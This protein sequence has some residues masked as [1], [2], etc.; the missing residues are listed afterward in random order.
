MS[1]H[2]GRIWRGIRT[3]R[4]HFGKK[5]KQYGYYAPYLFASEVLSQCERGSVEWLA[6]RWE[7][8]T[9]EFAELVKFA[10]QYNERFSSMEH[11]VPERGRAHFDQEWFS[12][13]DAVLAY[14]MVRKCEPSRIVEIGSGYSTCFMHQA[15][16]DGGIDCRHRCIDP[17]PGRRGIPKKVE[18]SAEPLNLTDFKIFRQLEPGDF[19]FVDGSHL[20][21]P[22]TDVDRLI[23]DI[24]PMLPVGV[25]VHFHDILLPDPYPDMW[26][27]RSYNEQD[28]LLAL[29][30]GGN[31]YKVI[32][33]AA[34]LRSRH[35]EMLKNLVAPA[36]RRRLET[37]LWLKVATEL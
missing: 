16:Q 12:G 25:M 17:A 32:A 3:I 7:T 36:L 21:H 26:A 15:V 4:A 29:L 28:A 27:W 33:P 19:L 23:R 5:G 10:E 22:C 34:F 14:A 9:D 24:L 6:E 11:A 37:S 31:R 2:I 20:Y 18:L 30:S 13:L 1:K 8:Q 35:P